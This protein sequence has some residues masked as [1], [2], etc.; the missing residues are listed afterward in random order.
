MTALTPIRASWPKVSRRTGI[1]SALLLTASLA[2]LAGC[3]S[4]PPPPP[5][6]APA[7]V[8]ALPPPPPPVLLPRSVVE[9]ASVYEG[10]VHQVASIAPAF[11]ASDKVEDSLKIAET[12]QSSQLQQ[13]QAAYGAVVALQDPTFVATLREFAKDAQQRS[14]IAVK[15]M[16]DPSYAASFKGADSAAGLVIATFSDQAK[17]VIDTGS[18]IHQAAYDVQHQ[19]WSKADVID[20]PGRLAL[21]K[22]LS[23]DPQKAIEVDTIRLSQNATGAQAMGMAAPSAPPPYTNVVNRSL[24]LAAM[25]ALGEGGEEYSTQLIALLA[26]PAEGQCLH[27]AKLDLYQCLSVAKPS[28]EDVFCMGQHA[29][30]ETG[31]CLMKASVVGYALPPTITPPPTEPTPAASTSKHKAKKKAASKTTAG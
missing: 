6:P 2:V 28:Y 5:P 22:A 30:G 9:L 1:K 7:P 11:T 10:Y 23:A 29:V 12:Y 19:S 15:L 31:Q 24:A 26:D 18:K 13:G 16:N 21:A 27:L 3:E 4:A 20:R 8:A 14:D 25:A 17:R